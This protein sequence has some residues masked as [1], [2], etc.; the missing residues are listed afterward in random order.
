MRAPSLRRRLT[1]VTLAMVAA[2]L[3]ALDAFIYL[4]L[5]EELE[6]SLISVLDARATIAAEISETDD[7]VTVAARLTEL[8]VP[9]VVRPGDGGEIR[10]DPLAQR[11]E[12]VPPGTGRR[13]EEEQMTRA[14]PLADGGSV[15]VLVSRGGV[16]RTLDRLRVLEAIGSAAAL[17][18]AA[19]LLWLA[20]GRLLRP[21]D[22]VVGLARRIARGRSGG[23]LH[24][25]RT[26]TE[27][28]RMAAAFDEMLD[29]L[30]A[31]LGDAR[32]SEAASRRFLADAAHQL[33]TPVAGARASA[34]AV[35]RDPDAPNRD[36]LL[37]S[38]ARES[39][40]AGRLIRTLLRITELDRDVAREPRPV[41]VRELMEQEVERQR[42]RAPRLEIAS[43]A[44]PDV[45]ERIHS[46]ADDVREALGNLLENASRHA[47][48]GIEVALTRDGHRVDIR[49][50]D[51]GPGL[52]AGHEAKAFERF[53]TLDGRGG[54]GLGLPIAR[55][56]ARRLG[57]D[58]HH[59]AGAFHLVLPIQEEPPS[60]SVAEPP[61]L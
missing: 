55:D 49:V 47:D 54:T 45:P 32:A 58:V 2:L 40:R 8:G 25:D 18:I 48:R 57:G 59:R 24:P 23:R 20:S 21:I 30:E 10:A 16:E 56:L 15:T 50:A 42:S 12:E 43:R 61:T 33:R 46:V 4:N 7:P 44:A 38:V 22:D 3:V 39:A 51:D 14:V 36:Q 1:A 28:G 13:L 53:V 5:R 52:A 29:S 26:D 17:G 11:F 19:V 31:A 9:A 6:D 37:G 34:E 41:D 60:P 27:L 35:L